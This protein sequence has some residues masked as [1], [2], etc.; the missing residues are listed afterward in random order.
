MSRGEAGKERETQN[1]KPAPGSKLSAQSPTWGSNSPTVRSW[2]E[3]KSEAQPT[4]PP[5]R[6]NVYLF[7]R[8]R[9]R[10]GKGVT[11]SEAGPSS[12]P[13]AQSPRRGLSQSQSL[14]VT[15]AKVSGPTDGA[16]RA[17]RGMWILI[18]WMCAQLKLGEDFWEFILLIQR[19]TH[20]MTPLWDPS[21]Q[22]SLKL[23][24]PGNNPRVCPQV[25]CWINCDKA[26]HD[27]ILCS[28]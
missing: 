15:W 3:P 2:P 18:G 5:R 13:S 8:D 22:R 19:H 7:L 20:K 12:K 10:G 9:A 27:A 6:P 24:K 23:Q 14:T 21:L 26:P 28:C 11:Q 4:E 25:R 1:L 16:S 17:P